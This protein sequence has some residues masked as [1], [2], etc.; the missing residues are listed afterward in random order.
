MF[1]RAEQL[2]RPGQGGAA[3][4]R[5]V[6]RRLASLAIVVAVVA[7]AAP[8]TA[9]AQVTPSSATTAG[10]DPFVQYNTMK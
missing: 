8:S 4:P 2:Q 6:W 9:P 10:T 1:R 5:R 7:A 3:T